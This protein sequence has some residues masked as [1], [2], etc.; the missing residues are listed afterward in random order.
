VRIRSNIYL[1]IGVT[2]QRKQTLLKLVLSMLL[3]AAKSTINSMDT[4]NFL[5][6]IGF[7]DISG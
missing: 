7:A 1:T 5:D 4:V 3:S 6:K 2:L